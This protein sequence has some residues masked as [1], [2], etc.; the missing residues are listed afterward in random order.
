MYYKIYAINGIYIYIYI[1]IYTHI[2]I[3]YICILY[4]Y[5]YYKIYVVKDERYEAIFARQLL[6]ISYFDCVMNATA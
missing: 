2:Y 1:Y 4:I 5:I 3:L 6:C